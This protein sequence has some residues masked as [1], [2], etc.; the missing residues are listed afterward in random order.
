MNRTD[1]YHYHY[2]PVFILLIVFENSYSFKFLLYVRSLIFIVL[3]IDFISLKLCPSRFFCYFMS[4]NFLYYARSPFIQYI[5][6]FFFIVFLCALVMKDIIVLDAYDCNCKCIL[7]V[8]RPFF[9]LNCLF[10]VR[11]STVCTTM[12]IFLLQMNQSSSCN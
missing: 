4:H 3:L 11:C 5:I 6:F 8:K 12:F 9:D 10:Y 7:V 2:I 1:H